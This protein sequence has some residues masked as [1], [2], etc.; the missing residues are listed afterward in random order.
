MC[1][2]NGIFGLKESEAKIAVQRM[3]S[4]LSHRGPDDEGIFETEKIVLGHRRLS[5]I[6][7]SAAGHQP[8]TSSDGRYTIVYNGELYNYKNL[9]LDLSRSMRTSTGS[10]SESYIF[11]TQ[12]DTEV[13]LAAY[14]KW[15]VECLQKFNGMY[16]FA[17]WDNAKQ[18]LFI[19][20]DRLGIKPLY[21]YKKESELIFSSE[22]RSVLNSG[23]VPRKLNSTALKEYIQYQTVHAP[24]TI[25]EDVKML[26][27]GHYIL[28]S[29]EKFLI[30]KYWQL[31]QETDKSILSKNYTETCKDIYQLLYNAVERRL[32][33]DVPFG[34]FLSGGIDSSAIVGLMSKIQA[35]KVKTFSVVFDEQE[36]SE[37]KYSR[38][39]AKKFNTDHHEIKLSISDFLKELPGAL[40]AMDHPSGDGPNT[41][42]VSKETKK[43]GITM[44][45]SGLGGDEIFAGY[46][47]FKRSVALRQ[48]QY[49][50]N[51]PV[52]LRKLIGETIK[53]YKPGVQSEKIAELLRLKNWNLE[54][55]YKLSRKVLPEKQA[56]K[57]LANPSNVN[58]TLEISERFPLL[59]RVSQ[60]E[61]TTYMQN[62]LLRDTDGMSMAHALEIRVPFLDYTL[63]EYMMSVPDKY[64]NQA[65]KKKLLVDSLGDM[66]PP[67][68][69]NRPKMGF[70]FPWKHWMKNELRSFCEERIKSLAK[71]KHFNEDEVVLLW[72]G[73]LNDDP[74]ITWSRIWHLVVLENWMQQNN[75]Q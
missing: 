62:V 71:R 56:D 51:V 50:E 70:T 61:I 19:A 29:G 18:E 13:I 26:L 14:S 41:Y 33:A 65:V 11:K 49:I 35:G 16:A 45:L 60:A 20:R 2:I 22:I 4:A 42:V 43:A 67:E 28:T 55:T 21:Y 17:I 54:S 31:P 7:L 5:I 66:L 32:I 25:I 27:P 39:I 8:M 10:S 69:V 44:A 23:L 1:G 9:K 24:G 75:I 64:K 58:F 74:R 68:I 72:E 63:V 53:K 52:I 59:S 38:L 15:G 46:D 3:N 57:L 12:T 30:K 34:A 48:K 40:S 6:D 37:A 47:I 36:F 73:F